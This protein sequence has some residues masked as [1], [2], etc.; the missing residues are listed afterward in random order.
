MVRVLPPMLPRRARDEAACGGGVLCCA[1]LLFV[2]FPPRPRAALR[3]PA[4]R[5]ASDRRRVPGE[6]GGDERRL[7]RVWLRF[8]R[9]C[10]LEA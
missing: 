7:A 9:A 8:I 1:V 2:G 6:P 4:P 10:L 3:P 5:S